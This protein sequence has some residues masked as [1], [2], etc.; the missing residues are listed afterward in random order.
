MTH[1]D[2]IASDLY[3]FINSSYCINIILNKIKEME[4]A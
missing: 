1:D 4:M 3:T 2:Y